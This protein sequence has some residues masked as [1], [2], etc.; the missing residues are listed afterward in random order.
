M[1]KQG[2]TRSVHNGEKPIEPEKP[3]ID[4]SKANEVIE[5]KTP[6]PLKPSTLERPPFDSPLIKL[7]YSI[8]A[9][10]QKELDKAKA[11]GSSGVAV[12]NSSISDGIQIGAGCKNGGCQ[13]VF[14]N[15]FCLLSCF[16]YITIIYYR[17]TKTNLARIPSACII[18]VSPSF[19]KDLN[20]GLVVPSEHPIL[21]LSWIK[22]AV[23]V[24]SMFGKMKR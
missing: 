24:E 11:D 10:L 13:V 14:S 17:L 8:S 18:L 1:I 15:S 7:K 16:Y 3:E 9:T 4:K 2:C 6:E 23:K 21:R 12:K 19:M 20:I 5:Y 22:K